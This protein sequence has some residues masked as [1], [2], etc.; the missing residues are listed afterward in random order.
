MLQFEQAT[1][2]ATYCSH[3]GALHTFAGGGGGGGGG[4][5]PNARGGGGGGGGGAANVEIVGALIGGNGFAGIGSE[6][7]AVCESS[8]SSSSTIEPVNFCLNL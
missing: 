5:I 7:A 1:E 2:V 6:P 4:G 3:P 8:S